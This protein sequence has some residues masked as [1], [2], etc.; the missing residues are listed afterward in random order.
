M[1]GSLYKS[2]KISKVFILF[3]MLITF[4]R[5]FTYSQDNIDVALEQLTSQI[6]QYMVEQKK[7]KIA[8][9]PF[10]DLQKQTITVL[11]SYLAEELTTNLFMTGKFKIVE[12]SL[13]KQVLDELKLSQTGVIDPGSAKELGKMA[14]VDAIVTGTIADLGSYVAVNCRLIETETGEVFAAA[15]AKIRKDVNI[16]KIMEEAVTSP[17]SDRSKE[18]NLEEHKGIPEGDYDVQASEIKT[19]GITEANTSIPNI[20]FGVSKILIRNDYIIIKFYANYRLAPY[21]MGPN[22]YFELEEAYI[23]ST[24]NLEKYRL[25][26][27]EGLD[28]VRVGIYGRVKNITGKKIKPNSRIWG[29]LYFPRFELTSPKFFLYINGYEIEVEL[30]LPDK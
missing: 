29:S 4:D 24:E 5:N 30:V 11:G 18:K 2:K 25:L 8:I 21:M 23:F 26:K 3:F 7:T 20:Y 9:I 10:S 19:G 6:N 27:V 28:S 12:R 13:M 22:S 15:K 16:E 17:K 1:E 14:G